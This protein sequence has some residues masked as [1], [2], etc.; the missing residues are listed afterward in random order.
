MTS[1]RDQKLKD[2]IRVAASEFLQR[3]GNYTSILT[4]TDISLSDRGSNATIFFT[5]L[6]ENKEKGALDFV[7]RKRAEFRDFFK[8]KARMRALP[9][10][11]FEIDRGEKNRQKIDE[12][13]RNVVE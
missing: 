12:I 13:A 9:F 5:V 11:D 6:P 7:K 1:D 10:F 4:V 8:N 3:E 2:V